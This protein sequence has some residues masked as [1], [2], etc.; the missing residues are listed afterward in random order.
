DCREQSSNLL[1]AELDDQLGLNRY[2]DIV[3]FRISHHAA[4][5]N[6]AFDQSEEI[7]DVAAVL[8]QVG[9]H[10][11]QAL[12]PGLD[13]DPVAGG[14]QV[15]GDIYGL[16]VDGDVPVRNELPG[17]SAAGAKSEPVH[18]VVEAPLEEAHQRVAGVALGARGAAEVSAK[19]P[20]EHA[21]VV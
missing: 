11:L 6:P 7:G 14:G 20:F 18:D 19:L 8:R 12:C 21:V 17:L 10:E 5:G 4:L 16:P 1:R 9:L 3:R 13:T 15:A 2:R